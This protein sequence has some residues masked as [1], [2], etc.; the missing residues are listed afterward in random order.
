MDGNNENNGAGGTP[1]EHIR[2][3]DNSENLV[4]NI[5]NDYESK[6]QENT[7]MPEEVSQ[8]VAQNGS[9]IQH[10]VEPPNE[11]VPDN[12]PNQFENYN[13]ELPP[14]FMKQVQQHVDSH[15]EENTL[16][17]QLKDPIVIFVLFLLLNLNPVVNLLDSVLSNYQHVPY[18]SVV[19][20]G[21]LAAVILFLVKK[22]L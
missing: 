8:E 12:Q 5:M 7:Q 2:T 1:I 21:V 6:Q 16:V 15:S 14:N 22:F 3:E 11:Y 9:Q 13:E 17:E 10:Q 4:N 19:I 18:L 20:R